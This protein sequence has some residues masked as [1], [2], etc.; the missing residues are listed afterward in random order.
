MALG[1]DS[2]KVSLVFSIFLFTSYLG[3]KELIGPP[4]SSY[5][6][7]GGEPFILASL[8]NNSKICQLPKIL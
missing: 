1:F 2:L 6:G 4:S 8:K 7:S 5:L 3:G